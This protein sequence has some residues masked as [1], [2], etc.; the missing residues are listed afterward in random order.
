MTSLDHRILIPSPPQAVWAYL[1]DLTNLP[2]W[3]VGCEHIT[4]LS[5]KR[6]GIGTRWRQRAT[7]RQEQVYEVVS[8]Y[9]ALGFEYILIDGVPYKSVQGRIRLQEIPEGTIIQ[10]SFNYELSGGV[11]GGLRNALTTERRQ[12][13]LMVDSLKTLWKQARR[14]GSLDNY[15]S[16]TLMRDG[17][18][19][20]PVAR[21]D[22]TSKRITQTNDAIDPVKDDPIVPSIPEPS[23]SDEDTRPRPSV[24][25]ADTL[26]SVALEATSTRNERYSPPD[27][28]KTETD[29]HERFAPPKPAEPSD[30]TL[31]PTM[32]DQP[33]NSQETEQA[34]TS[35]A[36][37]LESTS[38]DDADPD[39]TQTTPTIQQSD[40]TSVSRTATE[41]FNDKLEPQMQPDRDTAEV[42]IWDVFGI[43]SPTDTQRMRAIQVAEEA[44]AEYE[45]EQATM[46]DSNA[47]VH[48]KTDAPA[49]ENTGLSA[50]VNLGRA[51]VRSR[52][53]RRNI[54][55]RRPGV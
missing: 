3:Q 23:I 20:D 6:Q 31:P 9:D 18:P 38:Q 47:T 19:T 49:S 24:I 41:Q 40:A 12:D 36:A 42:S 45:A 51:G 10:W 43:P 55:I 54:K 1:S 5:Q 8:W 53:R 32:L 15:V 39:S 27:V 44:E 25:N 14:L 34:L 17:G 22:Y 48:A 2:E 26:P 28:E 37:E 4:F 13:K 33:A 52:L 16:P 46:P 11:L 21:A 7:N 50:E 29:E 30:F 35:S